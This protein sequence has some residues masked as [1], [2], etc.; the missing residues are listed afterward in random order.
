[1]LQIMS[2]ASLN[3]NLK[4]IRVLRLSPKLSI[5]PYYQYIESQHVVK[6]SF[7]KSIDIGTNYKLFYHIYD[8]ND[9]KYILNNVNHYLSKMT[10]NAL[11]IPGTAIIVKNNGDCVPE[12]LHEI[13]PELFTTEYSV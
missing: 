7:L 10:N 3:Q 13:L 11:M 6:N 1:M 8:K 5:P 4:L 2:S 9:I 12:N